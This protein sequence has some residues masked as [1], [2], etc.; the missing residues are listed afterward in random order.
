MAT[1]LQGVTDY[2]PQFQPFQPDL[3]FY[4]NVMQ[5]KQTQYDSNWKA[6]NKMYGQYYHADLT[7]DG[8]IA[9]RDSYLKN[10]EFQL[11]KIS[12]LDLSLE[13]NVAQATQVFKPFYEDKGLMKDM[14]W[15]KNYNNQLNRAEIF[16]NST[17]PDDQKQYWEA[18]VRGMNYLKDE[19]KEASEG[20][21]LGFQNA[22]YVPYVNVVERAQKVA[23]EADLS[24]EKVDFSPDGRWIVKTKNGKELTEPL[25]KLFEAQ[26]GSDPAIQ[27]VYRMQAYVDRKDYAYGNASMFGGDRNKAEMKYLENSFNV[28]KQRSDL[29]YKQLQSNSTVYDKKIK[30]LEEQMKNGKASP[31]AADI[32]EQYKMNKDINDKVLAR[33]EEEQKILSGSQSSTAT[34]ENGFKN[35]YGD[36]RTLRYKVD[37]GMASMLMQKDLDEAANIFAY[38]DAEMDI[39]ANPYAILEEKQRNSMQLIAAREASSKRIAAFKNQ[40]QKVKDAEDKKVED[41]THYRDKNGNLISYDN[42]NY[43][44]TKTINAGTS[45]GETNMKGVNKSISKMTKEEYADPYF[46]TTFAIIDQAVAGN[47]MTRK[48]AANILGYNK[49]LKMSHEQFMRSYQ[50]YGDPWLRK[51]VGVEGVTRI[52][53]KMNTWVSQ[54]RELSMFTEGGNKTELFR[55]YRKANADMNNYMLYVQADRKW[56]QKTSLAIKTQ[57]AKDGDAG[58]YVLFNKA[59]EIKTKKQFEEDLLKSKV[60]TKEELAAYNGYLAERAEKAKYQQGQ[61]TKEDVMMQIP[62]LQGIGLAQKIG[63]NVSGV[64]PQE[65]YSKYDPAINPMVKKVLEKYDYNT[66]V[67]KAN[68][69]YTDPKVVKANPIRLASGPVDPGTGLS[70]V[71]VSTITVNPKG[72]NGGK[73]HFG[74][75]M[76]DLRNF[77]FGTDKV[78]FSGISGTAY[79]KASG[80]SRNDIARRILEDLQREMDNPK[81]KMGT[82]D[83]TVSPI[84]AGKQGKAAVILELSKEFL[85]KYK[86][87]DKEGK[88]N[89][90]N[91]AQYNN[92][93]K[94]G[95]SFI[96]D[97]TKMKSTMYKKA[98]N[99]PLQGYVD[100]IGKYELTNIDGDP[101]KSYKI[102][103]NKLGTGDYITTITYPV[104]DM[105]TGK[106]EKDE[107]RE[108]IGFQG[109]SLEANRDQ[110]LYNF[111][112]MIDVQNTQLYNQYLNQR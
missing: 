17:D 41:G 35:P 109:G 11:Q 91:Q 111:Y 29:R 66:L 2:I 44:R 65:K 22:E 67:Q 107:Y 48:E 42:Q 56:N 37:N 97:D 100:Y 26:L 63:R 54:N 24:V 86:S 90:L 62:G 28:L 18:G 40:L 49:N 10:A 72:F 106:K 74:E 15:T 3:N 61:K 14:A 77:D 21:A 27:S 92:L 38:K 73:A 80:G 50:K 96:M 9:K 89:L 70:A 59:G 98:F 105:A 79:E 20:D 32:L 19:F 69:Y 58:A 68:K 57:M 16:R 85:D 36:L 81:S 51:Q 75:V 12:Q 102:E 104:F 78:S 110:V 5:T 47:K 83:I 82:F 1:Y 34:T 112:D 99:S 25:Q 103:P 71:N 53:G 4:A 43:V 23:K 108:N 46:A 76:R 88:N 93:L 31:D 13:Q 33:A 87:T 94:N 6:L 64:M 45:L 84:A 101:L 55:Q 95:M 39:E 7:R 60:F 52:R 8:N 30:D